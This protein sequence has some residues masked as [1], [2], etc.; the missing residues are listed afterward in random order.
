MELDVLCLLAAVAA[1]AGWVDAIAGGGGLLTIPALLLAGVPAATAVATNKLQGSVGT[2]VSTSYFLRQRTID[3]G[4]AKW[5]FFTALPLLVFGSNYFLHLFPLPTGDAAAA[6]NHRHSAVPRHHA[7]G[8]HRSRGDFAC[9]EHRR[10]RRA[11]IG[12]VA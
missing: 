12:A 3:F 8:Q 9:A 2:L 10:H 7:A 1:V 6:D 11:A 4:A 5:A